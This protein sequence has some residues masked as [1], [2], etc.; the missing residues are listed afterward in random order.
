M[1]HQRFISIVSILAVLGLFPSNILGQNN[2]VP[3]P[4]NPYDANWPP[5]SNNAPGSAPPMPP[6][7]SGFPPQSAP[8]PGFPPMDPPEE[9][10]FGGFGGGSG[11]G[12][13]EGKSSFVLV[14]PSENQECARWT[15]ELVKPKS[16]VDFNDCQKQ[17]DQI[18]DNGTDSIGVIVDDLERYKLKNVIRKNI[19]RSES[20]KYQLSFSSIQQELKKA[21]KKTC[22]CL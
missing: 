14:E 1:S 7:A 10:D 2:E 5:P 12:K 17:V 11:S 8:T 3:P 22:E 15:H 9:D 13:R 18:V 19:P 16:F 4:L 20:Q 21:R 6:G